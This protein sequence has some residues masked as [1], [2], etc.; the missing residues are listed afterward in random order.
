MAEFNI[1]PSGSTGSFTANIIKVVKE[2][3]RLMKE[4]KL[5][6]DVSPSV[7]FNPEQ[8]LSDQAQH[9][10]CSI[11]YNAWTMKENPQVN[12]S[13]LGNIRTA[14]GHIHVSVTCQGEWAGRLDDAQVHQARLVRMLDLFLGV[15][16]V[17]LDDD[18]RRKQFYGRAG[19]HRPKW[20]GV[21]YR[22]LSNFW[23]R[24]RDLTNW[25]HS[26]VKL[27]INSV[28]AYMQHGNQNGCLPAEHCKEIIKCINTNDKRLA[29]EIVAKY[30][31]FVPKPVGNGVEINFHAE[32]LAPKDMWL[33][34]PRA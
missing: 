8:L 7:E 1:Q 34:F 19:A 12:P 22:G 5:L 26:Q 11:D 2:L 23:I 18:V 21:E 10:G 28:N 33:N 16:S 9:V 25:V 17:L 4:Q 15:P 30:G 27:A 3:T 24:S 6:L 13:L 31:V 20:Y 32:N 29:E 14:G